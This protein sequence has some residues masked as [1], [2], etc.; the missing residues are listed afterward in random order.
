MRSLCIIL[1]ASMYVTFGVALVQHSTM[2]AVMSF[3]AAAMWTCN[4]VQAFTK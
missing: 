3:L 1:A 4:T 2:W